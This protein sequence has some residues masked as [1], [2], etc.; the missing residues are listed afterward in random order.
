MHE[1]AIAQ[2]IMKI[3]EAAAR[4]NS[5]EKIIGVKVEIGQMTGIDP[6]SLTFCFSALGKA[7]DDIDAS[8]AVLTLEILPFSAECQNC[9]NG[10]K[11]SKDTKRPYRFFCPHC[12]SPKINI[13]SG[14]ELKVVHIDIE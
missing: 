7:Q 3:A 2:G 1:M 10:I 8:E 5:A 13:V 4:E 14:K 12:G 9:R 6:D 11:F